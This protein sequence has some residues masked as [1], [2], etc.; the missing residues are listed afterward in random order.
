MPQ[1]LKCEV[2]EI[3]NHGEGVYSIILKP[4]LQ[5]PRF[6]AGQFLHLALDPY[7][8]GDY[9]PDSRVFSIASSPFDRN[10]LR[11][12]YA[13]KGK[14]TH[15]MEAELHCGSEVWVKLPYGEF[16]IDTGTDVCL[17]AGGTGVTAFTSFLSNLK[18]DYPYSIHLFYGA[19]RADLLVYRSLVE[20]AVEKCPNLHSYYLIETGQVPG[21]ITDRINLDHVW[22]TVLS[23][24]FTAFYLSGPP[25]MLKTLASGLI[26]RSIKTENILM[27]AWE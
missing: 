2:A 27:D 18:P 12:T 13:V 6:L 5:V 24:Q 20:T 3:L 15:R 22:K 16:T 10:L 14:F 7:S 8:S 26:D 17:L 25:I 23:P 19:R 4:E 21:Y 11:I 9:W 1:K